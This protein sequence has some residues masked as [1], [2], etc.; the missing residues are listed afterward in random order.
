MSH[1]SNALYNHV[2]T[3]LSALDLEIIGTIPNGGNW[4]DI[5]LH[6]AKKSERIMNIR[7]SGGRTTYYGRLSNEYPSYTI[8][9]YFH[10]PGNGTF[11]HPSQDR[12]ISQREAARLQSFPD[13]YRFLGS[14]SSIYKQIGNAVPVLLAQMIAEK[15][16]ELWE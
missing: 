3:R 14:S 5:P 16:L 9:T 12:M 15:L 6:V 8:N 1:D 13:H 4:Q 11:I 10:R 7:K 2:T